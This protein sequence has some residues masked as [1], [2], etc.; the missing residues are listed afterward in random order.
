M[1]RHLDRNRLRLLSV[2]LVMALGLLASPSGSLAQTAPA[3]DTP[4][5][6]V[7]PT[8]A[9]TLTPVPAAAA[10]SVSTLDPNILAN[11]GGGGGPRNLVKV[12][13]VQDNQLR[14][15]GNVQ[16]GRIP[17]PMVAPAN[18]AESYSSCT[19][20]QTLAV[21]LQVDLITPDSQRATPQ[22]IAV[23]VN[24]NCTD[25][26]T[27][28]VALQYVLTVDDPTQVPDEANQVMAEMRQELKQMHGDQSLTLA[29]AEARVIDVVNQ[30]SDL[31]MYLDQQ[32]DESMD[33]T[34]PNA[35]PPA[36]S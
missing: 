27:I 16:L 34:T 4:T 25:C 31:T 24:Y 20:C 32:R 35:P 8:P 26:D 11:L 10:P 5:P 19:S 21:A 13:N 14:V 33:L 29:D 22:N 30:F 3:T 12:Q 7:T 6:S 2:A 23:A 17:G 1:V 9:S 18:V 15:D 36:Q 28:A